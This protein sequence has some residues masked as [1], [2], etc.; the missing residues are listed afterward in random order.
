VIDVMRDRLRAGRGFR[1]LKV[2][3]DS[4]CE[5]A[6]IGS[7]CRCR[8]RVTR[9][10]EQLIEW[11]GRP[12]MIHCDN[13]RKYTAARTWYF[14][15]ARPFVGPQRKV[16]ALRQGVPQSVTPVSSVFPRGHGINR[17]ATGTNLADPD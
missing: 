3:D 4:V 1:P 7:I 11:R 16:A 9:S 17:L 2:L 5:G 10:L 6:R 15:E 8:A 13:G 12:P 14:P